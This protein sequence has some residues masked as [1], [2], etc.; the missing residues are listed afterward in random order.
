M[1]VNVV[2]DEPKHSSERSD[3]HNRRLVILSFAAPEGTVFPLVLVR[4][5]GPNEE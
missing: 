4:G 5:T 2:S 3:D 1:I